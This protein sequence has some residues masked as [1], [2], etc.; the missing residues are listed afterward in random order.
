MCEPVGRVRI[1]SSQ[2]RRD[3][4]GDAHH[5]WRD[6]I[7]VATRRITAGATYGIGRMSRSRAAT[8][9]HA[10]RTV[11]GHATFRA[12]GV[13][14]GP[15]V[16]VLYRNTGRHRSDARWWIRTDVL[17]VRIVSD[18]LWDAVKVRQQQAR[19]A[20]ERRSPR[21]PER[22]APTLSVFSGRPGLSGAPHK[23]LQKELFAEFCQ[24]FTR[25]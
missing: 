10:R 7:L 1:R 25:E 19:A 20:F 14:H 22:P 4:P 24:E 17:H 11:A 3:Q 15:R 13:E 6:E 16:R 23:L 2:R 18:E 5:A 21:R 9:P 8:W 12:H